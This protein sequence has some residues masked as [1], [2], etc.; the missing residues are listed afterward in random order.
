MVKKSFL[1]I[2]VRC[3]LYKVLSEIVLIK[4]F[5]MDLCSL[6]ICI[7]MGNRFTQKYD[8]FQTHSDN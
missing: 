7:P 1:R 3:S 6:I 5:T 8:C 2:F 4:P